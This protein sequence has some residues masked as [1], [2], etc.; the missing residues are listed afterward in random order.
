MF[1]EKRSEYQYP[2]VLRRIEVKREVEG[3]TNMLSL[4]G[5]IVSKDIYFPFVLDSPGGLPMLFV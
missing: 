2:S 5:V 1:N 4:V 3:N